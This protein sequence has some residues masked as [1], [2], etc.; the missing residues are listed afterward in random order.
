MKIYS[1][2]MAHLFQNVVHMPMFPQKEM[3]IRNE[4]FS[5]TCFGCKNVM[6][7]ELIGDNN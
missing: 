7:Y 6:K 4:S 3:L 2:I 5:I 1:F